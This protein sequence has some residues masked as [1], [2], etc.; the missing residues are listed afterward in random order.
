MESNILQKAITKSAQIV[1]T[2]ALLAL[3]A[4][5]AQANLLTNSSF[6]SPDAS[7]G[8]VHGAGAPWV[9]F[10]SNF[11]SSNLF[12]PGGLILHPTAHSGTQ[13]LKQFVAEFGASG[14]YQDIAASGGKTYEASAWA[15]SW[16]GDPN[17]NTGHM[18]MFFFDDA[19]TNLCDPD[20]FSFCA[21]AVFDTSQPID[22]WVQL[23][24]TAVAPEGTTIARIMLLLLPDENTP[25]NGS[26]YWD[27]AS[28]TQ[29]PV[30]AA[31]WL[32]GSGLLGLI[33]I[34][35]RKKA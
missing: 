6:E 4:G 14:S 13:V 25:A 20:G 31:V 21:Q 30:P 10:D 27:D 29:V 35:R 9:S 22:T 5:V 23:V 32:F 15:Q 1:G 2:G 34:A 28:L 11:T 7:A 26:L 3:C 18:L 33:G 17:N 19:T 24:T 16:A 8:D 12:T